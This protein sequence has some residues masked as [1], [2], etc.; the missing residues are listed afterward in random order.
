MKKLLLC[1]SFGMLAFVPVFADEVT[2]NAATEERILQLYDKVV[3]YD[4]YNENVF[5]AE[6]DDGILRHRN[7]HY[8]RKLTEEELDWCGEDLRMFITIGALCDNYDRIGN[9]NLAFVPKGE[10]SYAP[11]DVSRIELARFITPFMDMNKDPKE[12]PYEYYIP[13]VG[14]I[15]HDSNLREK[16]DFWL[17]FELFGIPYAANSQISGCKGRNDVF[18][19][20]LKWTSSQQP[21]EPNN[22]NVLVPVVIKKPEYISNNMNNYNGV[23]TDTIGLTTKTYR[24]DL[25]TDVEDSQ[26]VLIMSNHGANTGG[27]EYV[28]RLH[29]IYFDKE[30]V[31]SYK[32][33]G[34]SCEPYRKYNTQANGIY[35]FYRPEVFWQNSSNWCPGDVIPI[36]NIA[37]GAM[38]A[39]THEIMIRVPDARF[40]DRQGDFPVSIYVQ[41][42]TKGELP[43]SVKALQIADADVE[44]S[45]NGNIV[46]FSSQMPIAEVNVI[47]LDGQLLY[48][49]NNP[50]AELSLDRFVPGIYLVSA[51][52]NDGRSIV[53]K[54]LVK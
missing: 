54:V 11:N 8:S 2:D 14:N 6:K 37:I 42:I 5:D 19:G 53:R 26:I 46:H 34:K 49:V 47:S 31:K 36:R 45:V 32:P 23:A 48:A 15:L 7:S 12:V 39:G 1:C 17:E 50:S 24:F 35:A 28:R 40:A 30:I 10:E 4:G 44:I 43:S 18:E 3:F 33:G 38:K 13:A 41:G 20:T 21:S 27:E 16:Y 9:V 22:T 29:L 25:P 51:I 52:T